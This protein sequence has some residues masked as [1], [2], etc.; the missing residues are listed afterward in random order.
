MSKVRIYLGVVQTERKIQKLVFDGTETGWRKG[1]TFFFNQELSPDYLRARDSI[2]CMC[3][4]YPTYQQVGSGA[5]VPE[6]Y[7]SLYYSPEV[8]RF[9]IKD[10][11]FA[12]LE[13]FTTYLAQQYANGTPVCIWYVL[14]TPETAV[15]NEPLMRIGDYADA[16]SNVSIPV[17]AGE[18]TLSVDTTIQPSEVTVNYKGWHPVADV[19]E[20][21]SNYTIATMQALTI[22]QLQT[23]TISD[24][25]GGEWS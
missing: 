7:C 18:C 11:N 10:N 17:T 2:T 1:S 16:V 13:D 4:H 19:H 25:Q 3:S 9:Y 12:T 8:Q 24:L 23:H 14:A 21:D 20:Y 6:G 15:V 22:A 5:D